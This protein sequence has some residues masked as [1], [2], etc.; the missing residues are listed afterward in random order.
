MVAATV[1]VMDCI[2][3]R[4]STLQYENDTA[5]EAEILRDFEGMI[6]KNQNQT[7]S[8]EHELT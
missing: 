3:F 7:K 1:E 2:C 4:I 8:N 6:G 5:Y